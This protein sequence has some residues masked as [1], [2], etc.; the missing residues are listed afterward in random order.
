M[1]LIKKQKQKK[2][3]KYLS[4]KHADAI[5]NEKPTKNEQ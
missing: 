4:T 2:T 3:R 5:H 1:C